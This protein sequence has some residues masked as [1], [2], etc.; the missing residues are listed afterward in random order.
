MGL[1][2]ADDMAGRPITALLTDPPT[3]TTVPTFEDGRRPWK[4]TA[5]SVQDP[6]EVQEWLKS[7]GY[8][9]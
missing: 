4:A 6:V 9:Q 7:M 1:P 3:T 8:I 5:P 2:T